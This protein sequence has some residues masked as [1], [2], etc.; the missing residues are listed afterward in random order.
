MG[1]HEIAIAS[2]ES[3]GATNFLFHSSEL[4]PWLDFIL[5][6]QV[7]RFQRYLFGGFV[8]PTLSRLA[9]RFRVPASAYYEAQSAHV[10]GNMAFGSVLSRPAW[11]ANFEPCI[12]S[13]F[14][15]AMMI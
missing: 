11:I 12:R 2:S 13:S 1:F 9:S 8:R 15:C 3:I 14:V 4:I 10:L 5:A 7:G 6:K